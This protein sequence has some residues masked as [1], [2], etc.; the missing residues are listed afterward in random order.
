MALPLTREWFESILRELDSKSCLG[1]GD[2]SV[3]ASITGLLSRLSKDAVA[4]IEDELTREG[5]NKENF[6][7]MRE[8]D[9]LDLV[10]NFKGGKIEEFRLAQ[11]SDTPTVR[12]SCDYES[13]E[14]L[15]RGEEDIVWMVLMARIKIRGKLKNFTRRIDEYTNLIS[16]LV[17][18]TDVN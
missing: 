2:E 12:I 5:M 3:W 1:F 17:S 18:N 10:V 16:A 8:E 4:R 9:R 13:L 6:R 14:K 15:W 11:P 7:R